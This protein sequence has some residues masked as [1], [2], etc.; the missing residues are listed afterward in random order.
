MAGCGEGRH[1]L[2]GEVAPLGDLPLVVGLD[3]HRGDE[4]EGGGV[5]REDPDDPG[6]ALDLGVE[7]LDRVRGPDFSFYVSS[8]TASA[9]MVR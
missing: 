6:A 7:P 3:D 8:R 9:S 2:F 5:V 4:A 1:G